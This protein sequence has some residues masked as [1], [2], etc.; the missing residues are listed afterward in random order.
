M[1][2][3]DKILTDFIKGAERAGAKVEIKMPDGIEE[4]LASLVGTGLRAP[5]DRGAQ[6]AYARFG[7]KHAFLG[8]LAPLAGSIAGP[9]LA[10]GALGKIAPAMAKGLGQGFKGQAFDMAASMGGQM[11]G[12]KLMGGQQQG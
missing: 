7:L 6:A 3:V 8:A 5:Y 10:R 11:L 1:T 2:A 4:K 9:A 12:S